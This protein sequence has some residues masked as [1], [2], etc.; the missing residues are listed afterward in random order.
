MSKKKLITIIGAG[1][2]GVSSAAEIV[3]NTQHE[4]IIVDKQPVLR[5]RNQTSYSS[6]VVH[7]GIF[8]PIQ[9]MPE[10]AELCV[11]GNAMHYE[12]GKEH[13]TPIKKTEKLM[14]A[15]TPRWVPYLNDVEKNAIDAGAEIIRLTA[16]EA[17]RYERN[18]K[19]EAALLAPTSGIIDAVAYIEKLA[20]L[21]K[22][23]SNFHSDTISSNKYGYEVIDIKP[24]GCGFEITAR[25]TD[26]S[27]QLSQWETDVVINCA[28][29]YSDEIARMINPDSPY[30]IDPIRGEAFKFYKTK[31]DEIWHEGLNIYHAPHGLWEDGTIADIEFGEFEKLLLAGEIFKTVGVHLTPTFAMNP[32][33]GEYLRDPDTGEYLVDKTVTVGPAFVGNV[34]KEDYR[35]T[36][37]AEF[38]FDSTIGYWPGFKGRGQEDGDLQPHQ[39][40]IMA[41]LKGHLD[42]VNGPD[43]KYENFYNSLGFDTPGITSAPAFA[44]FRV[45]PYIIGLN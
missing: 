35:I 44:K 26:A 29:L 39:A 40:G 31:R 34:G 2:A 42:F 27:R 33:T 13:G 6:G 10:K 19:V 11:L 23:C 38:F 32:V 9:Y 12:F 7:A 36:K 21:L 1:M 3:R 17:K 5:A 41:R 16:E 24:K 15:P 14:V 45:L 30:E 18:V 8:Y 25:T 22:G 43:P 20:S 4:V 37:P 28:G